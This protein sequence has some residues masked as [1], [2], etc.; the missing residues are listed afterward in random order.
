MAI[1]PFLSTLSLLHHTRAP[2]THTLVVLGKN[3]WAVVN[4]EV[5][6]YTNEYSN[7]MKIK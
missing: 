4:Y 3:Q 2:H 1:S 6:F 5:N 7:M